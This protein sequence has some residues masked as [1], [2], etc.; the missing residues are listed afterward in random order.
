MNYDITIAGSDM[1]VSI[2]CESEETVLEAV[3]RAGFAIPYSCL[4]GVCSTCEGTLIAG[5]VETV[6]RGLIRGLN[7]AVRFCCTKPRSNLEIRPQKILKNVVPDRKKLSVSV[8]RMTSLAEDVTRLELRLPMGKRC[9]FRAGQYLRIYLEDGVS[10]SYS[11]ANPPQKNNLL[12][13]HIR[14]FPGGYFSEVILAQLESKAQLSIEL[15]YGQFMLNESSDNPVILIASGTGFA[16]IKSMIED[17]L[18]RG[19]T[20]RMALYWGARSREDL[21]LAELVKAWLARAPWLT[22]TPVLSRPDGSWEGREGWVQHAVLADH[23]DLSGW[24][25]Y[26]CGNPQMISESKTMFSNEAGLNADNF[27]CDPFV[28]TGNTEKSIGSLDK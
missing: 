11:M 14:H 22:F 20:R 13:L 19:G 4:K 25:V 6:G 28:E 26:A 15:P 12:E 27:Y 2:P 3:E 7:E 1:D 23:P 5:E 24:E 8:F 9:K 10:R 21:Y 17:Q 18:A 16:P